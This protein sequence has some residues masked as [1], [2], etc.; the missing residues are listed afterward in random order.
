MSPGQ[1]QTNLD[2]GP[3]L[4]VSK[5]ISFAWF[6]ECYPEADGELLV[7]SDLFFLKCP[8]SKGNNHEVHRRKHCVFRAPLHRSSPH[9][10]FSLARKIYVQYF[11]SSQRTPI[12]TSW[13]NFSTYK[14]RMRSSTLS[15]IL[16][17]VWD[18]S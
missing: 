3:F 4:R 8:Y 6:P 11:Q 16:T 14:G 9:F 13:S 12:S 17:Q 5:R 2:P 1:K 10:L 18:T 15:W 7:H